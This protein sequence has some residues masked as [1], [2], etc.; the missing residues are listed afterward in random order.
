MVHEDQKSPP[1]IR[2]RIF[3]IDDN[4]TTDRGGWLK[5]QTEHVSNSVDD[6]EHNY[7]YLHNH[8]LTSW[9]KSIFR[10]YD[11]NSGL[12]ICPKMIYSSCKGEL[13]LTSG[14]K[15]GKLV[16]GLFGESYQESDHLY[17]YNSSLQDSR[18]ASI[19]NYA[20]A[21]SQHSMIMRVCVCMSEIMHGPCKGVNKHDSSQLCELYT[22]TSTST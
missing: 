6:D 17:Q 8:E 19:G 12:D 15:S 7:R 22:T 10:T 3:A 4:L 1:H 18:R 13:A 2:F 9:S 20:R 21:L 16:A 5:S 14:S 11:G